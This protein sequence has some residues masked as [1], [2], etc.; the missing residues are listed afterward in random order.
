M[1]MEMEREK[2]DGSE[3]EFSEKERGRESKGWLRVQRERGMEKL[4]DVIAFRYPLAFT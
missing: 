3:K 4:K 1:E 2:K